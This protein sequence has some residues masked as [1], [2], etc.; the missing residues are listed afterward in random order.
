MAKKT[1]LPKETNRD[2]YN[3]TP[4]SKENRPSKGGDGVPDDTEEYG[5]NDEVNTQG[6]TRSGGDHVSSL[7]QNQGRKSK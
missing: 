5:G 7:E 4:K 2:I 3:P 1:D 6:R